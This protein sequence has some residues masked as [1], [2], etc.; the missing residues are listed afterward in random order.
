MNVALRWS[1][2]CIRS[3]AH[4]YTGQGQDGDDLKESRPT[5]RVR[6]YIP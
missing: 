1:F 5:L 3:D 4:Q 6:T 2:L